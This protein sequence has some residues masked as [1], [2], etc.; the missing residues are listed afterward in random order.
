MDCPV[1]A[2]ELSRQVPREVQQD[3]Y[4]YITLIPRIDYAPCPV[5]W[6]TPYRLSPRGLCLDQK[7]KRGNDVYPWLLP[8]G[9]HLDPTRQG[10]DQKSALSVELYPGYRARFCSCDKKTNRLNRIPTGT[11]YFARTAFQQRV[12]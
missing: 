8:S 6:R 5:K 12:I 4:L 7:S 9:V 10:R 1:I 2:N 11:L 3:G